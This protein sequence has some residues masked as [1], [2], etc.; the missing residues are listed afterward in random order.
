EGL[1]LAHAGMRMVIG[2]PSLMTAFAMFTVFDRVGRKKGGKGIFGWIKKMPW[3]DVRFLAPMIAMTAFIPGGAG[4]IAQNANQLNQV[5]H[6]SLWVVG[7]FHL[8]VGVTAVLTFFGV[9][10]WLVPYLSKRVLTP[11]MNKLGIIQVLIWTVGMIFMAG[12]MH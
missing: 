1:K 10:Y 11:Q 8:T 9:V 12:G 6:N 5:I 7:H 4:G 3:T 2:L